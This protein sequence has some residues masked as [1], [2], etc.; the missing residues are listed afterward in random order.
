MTT[1][2]LVF[3]LLLV[4][5]L[6]AN[7]LLVAA[8]SDLSPMGP[9]ITKGAAQ[10]GITIRLTFASSGSLAQ[11]IENGAPYD[12]FLSASEDYVIGLAAKGLVERATVVQYGT[13]RLGMFSPVISLRSLDALRDKQILHIA[14][15]NPDHAPY[16][17]A[18]R[19]ALEAKSLWAELKSK[20]VY[21]ENVRQAL[22]FVESGNADA[23]LTSWTLLKGRGLLVPADL[24]APLR[25]VGAV[26]HSST[27]KASAQ[28]FL[29][30]LASAEGRKILVSGGLFPP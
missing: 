2:R 12:V 8:A 19:Q 16:G 17:A 13:G 22:Q 11:Q 5:P 26:V 30:F 20:L 1:P 27:E 29:N 4:L 25:Q 3:L 9:A 18:A 7:E 28:R 14:M 23:V 6:R 21:G 15:A 24:H 10:A